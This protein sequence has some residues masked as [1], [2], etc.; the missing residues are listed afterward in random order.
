MALSIFC[1]HELEVLN[2]PQKSDITRALHWLGSLFFLC[3]SRK[4]KSKKLQCNGKETLFSIQVKVWKSL[5][6]SLGLIFITAEMG[7]LT[8]VAG[9]SK[10][11]AF[12]FYVLTKHVYQN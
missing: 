11:S 5:V 6:I 2:E 1:Q 10:Q 8:G 9:Q 3:C 4:K 7:A 12:S